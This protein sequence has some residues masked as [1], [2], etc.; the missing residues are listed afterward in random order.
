MNVFLDPDVG[1][2]EAD[3]PALVAKAE[4]IVQDFNP[5]AS[6]CQ[7]ARVILERAVLA[8]E[9]HEPRLALCKTSWGACSLLSKAANNLQSATMLKEKRQ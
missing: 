1:L 3:R 4:A 9:C 2:C 6:F 8:L 5:R 7:Q